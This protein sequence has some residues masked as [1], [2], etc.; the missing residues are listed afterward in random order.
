MFGQEDMDYCVWFRSL[1]L[2]DYGICTPD[3]EII[4]NL[5]GTRVFY[6]NPT[7]KQGNEY[8]T[9][10]HPSSHNMLPFR[11]SKAVTHWRSSSF[12]APGH[13]DLFSL[14]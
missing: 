3:L 14:T 11:F 6:S 5:L 7:A 9:K 4:F 1:S 8:L 12:E 13:F 2:R 10:D